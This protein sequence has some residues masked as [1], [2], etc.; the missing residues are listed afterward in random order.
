MIQS[1][2]IGR[3]LHI[4]RGLPYAVGSFLVRRFWCHAVNCSAGPKVKLALSGK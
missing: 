3:E 1:P 2:G 4:T